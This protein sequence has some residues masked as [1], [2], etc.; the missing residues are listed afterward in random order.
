MELPC[1]PGHDDGPLCDRDAAVARVD[2]LVTAH[3][4][5]GPEIPC[6]PALAIVRR[7]LDDRL[8]R[9][10]ATA[11]LALFDLDDFDAALGDLDVSWRIEERR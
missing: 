6:T 9:R 10:G 5:H 7:L 8:D 11:C 3:R 1:R 4:N 2:W